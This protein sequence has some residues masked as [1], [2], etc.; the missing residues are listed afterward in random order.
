MEPSCVRVLVTGGGGFIGS[1]LAEHLLEQGYRVRVLD[2]FAT[3]RRSN[4]SR[5]A[6][7]V[8]LIEG[9]IQSYRARRARRSPAARSSSTRPR[10]PPSA[11]DPGSADEQ[12]DERHR[13][14]QR[15]AR[16]ARHGV[17]RVVF[18][19]SSSVYGT[20]S[21]TA[22]KREDD[23]RRPDLAVRD[24]KAR[25]RGLRRSFHGVYGL[26]TVALRYFNVFGP[27]QDPT[28]QYAAVDPELHHRPD[29]R[30]A[31]GHLRRRRAVARLH[32]R[33]Q[34]RAGEHAGDGRARASPA[35]STTSPAVSG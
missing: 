20:A 6:G 17:R 1:H 11:L 3:G 21:G 28:S 4:V 12:R 9:D 25:R 5:L 35:G 26:D 30:P 13:D 14:A 33:G 29:G 23:A 32:L 2:N 34:R 7:E 27:R 24:G 10:C 31:T 15:A 19:S 18:A 8:E 16:R 22:P